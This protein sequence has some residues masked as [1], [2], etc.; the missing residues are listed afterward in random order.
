M[1][2]LQCKKKKEKEEHVCV[3]YIFHILR[4][5]LGYDSTKYKSLPKTSE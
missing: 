3:T 4:A 5:Y 1:E 2:R